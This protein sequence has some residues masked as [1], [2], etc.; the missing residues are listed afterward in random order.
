M[1]FQPCLKHDKCKFIDSN[2]M[3]VKSKGSGTSGTGADRKGAYGL[4]PYCYLFSG[5]PSES[6]KV[7]L[8]KQSNM[9]E[10]IYSKLAGST[11]EREANNAISQ[12]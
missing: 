12:K 5:E 4:T 3:D 7:M 11:D 6:G 9:R 8:G 2:M 10:S 1:P